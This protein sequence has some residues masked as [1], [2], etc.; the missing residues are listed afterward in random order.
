MWDG[1]APGV[2]ENPVDRERGVLSW[3]IEGVTDERVPEVAEV[4][5]NLVGPACKKV[6]FDQ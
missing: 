3:G 5:T 2:Q 4:N 1:Q 6:T